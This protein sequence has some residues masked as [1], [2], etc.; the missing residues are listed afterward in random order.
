MAYAD[1]ITITSTQTSTSAAKKCIQPY[2]HKVVAWTKQNNFILNP[3]KTTCT[4]FTPDPA[5]YMYIYVY[6]RDV[7]MFVIWDT[8]LMEMVNRI[9]LLQLESEIDG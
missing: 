5:E 1:D 8:L 9:L 4:L 3:D 7:C 6:M 2:L